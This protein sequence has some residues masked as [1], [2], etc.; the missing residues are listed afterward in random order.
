MDGKGGKQRTAVLPKL[1][2]ESL[3]AHLKGRNVDRVERPDIYLADPKATV[4][5]CSRQGLQV[6]LVGEYLNPQFALF[7]EHAQYH[8]EIDLLQ[9]NIVKL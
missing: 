8:V 7:S 6:E 1:V 3:E 4:W 5:C 9:A 2:L